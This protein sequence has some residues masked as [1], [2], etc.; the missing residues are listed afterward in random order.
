MNLVQ[1]LR[2]CLRFVRFGNCLV[3]ATTSLAGSWAAGA[4]FQRDKPWLLAAAAL[5]I[6]AFGNGYN[7][8]CDLPADRVNRPDRVLPR[9]DISQILALRIA[10]W[11]LVLGLMA[12]AA[13]YVDALII[14]IAVSTALFLYDRDLKSLPLVGNATVAAICATTVAFGAQ[15]G[16][17]WNRQ[18]VV[19]MVCAFS[20]T[21]VRELYKDIED[22]EG[23]RAMGARTYPILFGERSS[24]MVAW[25]PL[26]FTIYFV[27][28]RIL[29]STPNWGG[30]YVAGVA[31]TAGMTWTGVISLSTH[32]TR[33]WHRRSTEMKLW[34]ILGVVWVLLWRIPI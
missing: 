26:A 20:L 22:V 27:V 17:E 3:A 1:K 29:S 13:A 8:V 12:A 18:V 31:L 25:V 21:L 30:A 34:I 23:D 5:L 11:C 10:G 4:S 32:D 7:D 24:A 28:Y 14:A 15:A 2:A 33:G 19:L 16:K 9:G 6:A